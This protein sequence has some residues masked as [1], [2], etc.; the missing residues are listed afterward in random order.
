MTNV[1]ELVRYINSKGWFT[2]TL[3]LTM[4]IESAFEGFYGRAT[5]TWEQRVT[6]E[7]N[8]VREG[9]KIASPAIKIVGKSYEQLNEV[10]GRV[11]T[12]LKRLNEQ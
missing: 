10:A 8:E 2:G 1:Q 9:D 6:I 4:T 7:M 11:L 12:E 3:K 5:E